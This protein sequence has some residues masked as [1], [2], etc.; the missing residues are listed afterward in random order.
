MFDKVDG[1]LE[2]RDYNWITYLVLFG[3]EK[4]DAIFNRIKYLINLKSSILSLVSCNY[5]RVK[6]YSDGDLPLDGMLS[7]HFALLIKQVLNKNRNTNSTN[8]ST[9]WKY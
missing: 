2:I 6:G 4:N 3:S 1:L 9:N 8:W 7:F 5:P